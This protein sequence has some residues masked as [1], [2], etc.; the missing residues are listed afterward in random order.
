MNAGVPDSFTS[1]LLL[2]RLWCC[3]CQNSICFAQGRVLGFFFP[4]WRTWLGFRLWF[5]FFCSDCRNITDWALSWSSTPG[6]SIERQLKYAAVP[7]GYHSCSRWMSYLLH[8]YVKTRRS[9]CV[10][11][12]AALFV[13]F[14]PCDW[15]FQ[16]GFSRC[17]WFYFFALPTPQGFT[18][19]NSLDLSAVE[20]YN[21]SISSL[22]L[23]RSLCSQIII[24]SRLMKEVENKLLHGTEVVPGLS[25]GCL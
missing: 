9:P 16:P 12:Y 25:K 20:V 11:H 7:P 4:P 17:L 24:T 6:H 23:L 5:F 13:V 14:H 3:P 1:T 22:A 21:F 10:L 19:Y 8:L 18:L 2:C 15:S